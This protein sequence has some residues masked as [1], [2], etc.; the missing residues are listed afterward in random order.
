ML[1]AAKRPCLHLACGVVRRIDAQDPLGHGA[2]AAAR[3]IVAEAVQSLP[4]GVE[5]F[6][7]T[8]SLQQDVCEPAIG[9]ADGFQRSALTQEL[10]GLAF[11]AATEEAHGTSS[12]KA[13]VGH[14]S[15]VEI[16][17]G[18]TALGHDGGMSKCRANP[19]L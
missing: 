11:L 16:G 9:G 17:V 15:L 14:R 13:G 3:A 7:L 6:P 8:A 2:R 4:Q 18:D 10:E 19:V 1:G 5:G 12:L